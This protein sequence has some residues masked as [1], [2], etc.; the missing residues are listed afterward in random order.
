[1]RFCLLVPVSIISIMCMFRNQVVELT[2]C[3][4]SRPGTAAASTAAAPLPTPT[5]EY[6]ALEE[7]WVTE[8]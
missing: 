6:D 5:H 3:E 2:D 8:A 1:M 7:E 4:E